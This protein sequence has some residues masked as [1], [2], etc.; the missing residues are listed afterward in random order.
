[1]RAAGVDKEPPAAITL[2]LPD[3][4]ELGRDEQVVGGLDYWPQD[5]GAGRR[6]N[7]V[8]VSIAL[9]PNGHRVTP[10]FSVH[11]I[12]AS[13]LTRPRYKKAV[14][15]LAESYRSTVQGSCGGWLV[16]R[17]SGDR[18]CLARR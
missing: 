3:T 7:R 14:K 16:V 1:M 2:A 12:E 10:E 15:S 9:E 4:A 18:S 11:D 5:F 13:L 6:P 8:R 17:P